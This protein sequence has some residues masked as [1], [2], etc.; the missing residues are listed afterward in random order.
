VVRLYPAKLDWK[1]ARPTLSNS[2][3]GADAARGAAR[4]A[5]CATLARY[6]DDE[7]CDIR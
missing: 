1:E 2:A 5:N 6:V 3:I 4:H 7:V